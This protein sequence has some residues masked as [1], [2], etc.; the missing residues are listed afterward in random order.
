MSAGFE[1]TY[2]ESTRLAVFSSRFWQ[3]L[4]IFN[5]YRI[6]IACIVLFTMNHETVALT[7]VMTAVYVF[8]AL[9]SLVSLTQ[10]AEPYTFLGVGQSLLDIA[11]FIWLV[12]S[13]TGFS[14]G[15]S[16]LINIAIAG[17]CLMHQGRTSLL[18]AGIASVL[19]VV[20]QAIMN[21]SFWAGSEPLFNV[22]L[23]CASF[24]A[25]AI[26]AHELSRRVRTSERI[27]TERGVDL[28]N[29]QRLN[30]LVIDRMNTGVV[31]V[32]DGGQVCLINQA[33]E[34]LLDKRTLLDATLIETLKH[35]ANHKVFF[36]DLGLM[37]VYIPSASHGVSTNLIFIDS[38]AEWAEQAQQMK[39]ASLGRF[40]A[41]IAH[42]LRNPLGAIDHAAQLLAE[43]SELPPSD[44]R[45]VEIIKNHSARMNQVI[46]NILQ[47]SR[48]D[49]ASM[50]TL[51]LDTWLLN[52]TEQY[53]QSQ[54]ETVKFTLQFKVNMAE[55]RFDTSHLQQ[56]LTNLFDNGIRYSK[57]H[58][59]TTALGVSTGQTSLGNYYIDVRDC[60]PG[61]SPAERQH[62][63]E[64]FYTTE[65]SGTGLGL[66]LAKELC[67]MNQASLQLNETSE[68][69]TCFRILFSRG[70]TCQDH[71]HS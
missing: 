3:P 14:S 66:Y 71:S 22:A 31:V 39:L 52:F 64:P 30:T 12:N 9:L 61:I 50:T 10:R 28:A 2:N 16:I 23:Y 63:F 32:D 15:L 27:A 69:G 35:R 33:A 67:E 53:Q 62:L 41:S 43:S 24:F 25:T 17:N 57:R 6:C 54:K 56:I 60:G 19:F 11:F 29:L 44:T 36:D 48:R 55:I 59:G 34:R 47:L 37:M 4:Q 5:V 70:N 65:R 45:L 51:N 7:W 46:K 20:E 18:F 8:V 42:E 49:H 68:Q 38:V 58:S 1:S 40:T 26:L 13:N 21:A